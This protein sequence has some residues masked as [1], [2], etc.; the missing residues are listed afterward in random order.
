MY[1][2]FVAAALIAVFL[3]AIAFAASCPNL[4]RSLSF[5]SRGSDVKQLQQFL[6][7]K[8]LL[9]SDSATGYFG[10]LT[11]AAV[12]KFQCAQNIVCAGSPSTTGYGAVGP[13]TRAAIARQCESASVHESGRSSPPDTTP[14][15]R[16]VIPADVTNTPPPTSCTSLAPQTQTLSCPS[17]QTGSITRTRTSSCPGPTWGEWM[18]TATTCRST[19]SEVNVKDFGAKGDGSTDDSTRIQFAIN[20]L[21]ASGGVIY[22][23][24]GTYMLG[25]SAGGVE[26]FPNGDAIQ[27]AIIINKS[28]VVFKGAGTGVTI[29]KLMPHVKMRAIAITG[30]Y[31]TVDGLTVDGNKTYRDGAA[32]YPTGDVVDAM[33]AGNK[34]G[35]HITAQNCEARNGIEDGIGFWKSD[36]A[37]VQNCYSH[38]NGTTQ[39]GG[40]GIALS[41]GARARAIGNRIENNMATGIWSAYGSKD[42]LIQNNIIK[43]N[44]KAGITIGGF[45]VELGAGGNSG[46]TISSNTISG[47]GSAGF[48]G[49]IVAS[50]NN[51][52]ITGNTIDDNAY[53]SIAV[54]DDGINPPSIGWTITGNSC[55]S[56]YVGAQKWG[57]RILEKSS[58]ILRENTCKHNGQSVADQIIIAGTASVNSDWQTANTI[59]YPQ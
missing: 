34:A 20:S 47:N 39:A 10:R 28:N 16:P 5:G 44:A 9:A 36:D 54:T 45:S 1:R 4:T 23:P 48:D 52:T 57:I 46:F 35:N 58:V 59:S 11:E 27:N 42:V 43:N 49:V 6:I 56:S 12:K 19:N 2:V 13:R 21:P 18:T 51:G 8:N 37:T 32:G 3:P 40:A 15:A 25:T 38:D 53:D 50:A 31:V 33:I 14:Y 24:P 30:S 41:G 22:I 17:G 26:N 55:S 7:S 29:L